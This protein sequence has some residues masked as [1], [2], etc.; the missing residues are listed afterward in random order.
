M[1]VLF[2]AFHEVL[3]TFR[4]HSAGLIAASLSK[5]AALPEYRRQH[6]QHRRQNRDADHRLDQRERAPPEQPFV[7]IPRCC[8][9]HR[10]GSPPHAALSE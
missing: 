1:Q 7:P 10:S 9:L 3:F 5:A 2:Y 8:V 4:P 6:Q